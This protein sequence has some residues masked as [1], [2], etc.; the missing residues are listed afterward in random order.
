MWAVPFVFVLAVGQARTADANDTP[1]MEVT[2]VDA[3]VVQKGGRARLKIKSDKRILDVK[4]ASEKVVRVSAFTSFGGR[5]IEFEAL[6]V[7]NARLTLRDVDGKED[8]VIVI[9][10]ESS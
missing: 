2:R 1:I 8:K 6:M 3:V 10:E 7:G 4:N 5:F 9:V